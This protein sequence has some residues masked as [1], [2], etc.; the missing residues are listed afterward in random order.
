[1]ATMP[2]FDALCR[3]YGVR[4]VKATH[5]SAAL[6]VRAKIISGFAGGIMTL[7]RGTNEEHT[8]PVCEE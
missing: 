1:M 5:T 4:G 3:D 2:L 7:R 8:L 6:R